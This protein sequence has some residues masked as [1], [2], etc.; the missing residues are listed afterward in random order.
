MDVLY[1]KIAF[2]CSKKGISITTMCKDSGVS[3]AALSDLRMGRSKTLSFTT[4]YKI[5]AYFDVSVD[6]LLG[7]Y[8]KP[9]GKT[10]STSDPNDRGPYLLGKLG[11]GTITPD[12][13]EELKTIL[14]HNRIGGYL[15]K[16]SPEGQREAEKRVKE[17][18]EIPRYQSRPEAPTD[19]ETPSEG[20]DP[21]QE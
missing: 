16:L 5:A 12:E 17:L 13:H 8:T 21:A 7:T 6:D 2:L 4:L 1:D 14:I 9:R 18:T 15:Q 11:D 20:K 10:V 19:D 3:R